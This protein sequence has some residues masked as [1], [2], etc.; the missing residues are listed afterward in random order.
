MYFRHADAEDGKVAS[1]VKETLANYMNQNY[2][3]IAELVKNVNVKMPWIRMFEA[4]I[5]LDLK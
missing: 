4:D 1:Y 2:P 5:K 3:E